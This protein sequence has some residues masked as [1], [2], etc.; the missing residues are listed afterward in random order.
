PPT[1][2]RQQHVEPRGQSPLL[3]ELV[4]AGKLPPLAERLPDEPIVMEGPDG[5]G[6]YGGTWL[7]LANG[8]EVVGIITYRLSGPYLV[9]WSPLGY[10]IE[11]H[12][13]KS[14]EPSEDRREW[15][16]T[17]RKGMRWS[18]GAPYA[19]DDIMYWWDKEVNNPYLGGLPPAFM[20]SAGKPGTVE[21]IDDYR[22]CFRFPEPYPLFREVL[23]NVSSMCETPAHYLSRYH[24]DPAIGDAA[25]I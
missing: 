13:A 6:K 18:D 9:R 2:H 4:E 8:A 17:L 24:P 3:A 12:I 15:I 20:L 5:I 21:K 1:L 19:A 7:R 16:I 25:V 11:N 10:P 23:A 22:V 14:V